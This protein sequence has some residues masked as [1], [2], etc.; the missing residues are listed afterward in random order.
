MARGGDSIQFTLETDPK[1]H[2]P[3]NLIKA[4]EEIGVDTDATTPVH[5]SATA[6]FAHLDLL[7]Y[8]ITLNLET[9]FIVED[10]V[11]WDMR[12]K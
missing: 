12:I 6:W 2:N 8:V 10:D 9:A 11:N 3:E 5:G 1:P 4:F 7:K